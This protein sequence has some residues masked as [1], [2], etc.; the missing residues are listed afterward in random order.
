MTKLSL[1]LVLATAAS[2]A[3][4]AYQVQRELHRYDFAVVWTTGQ[5]AGQS[6][7]GSFLY[8]ELV[9]Y[10][11]FNLAAEDYSTVIAALLEPTIVNMSY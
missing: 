6:T 5:L 4:S 10:D 9:G 7:V 2:P 3:I 8:N 11:A 1:A